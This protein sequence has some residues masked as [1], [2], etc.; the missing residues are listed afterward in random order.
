MVRIRLIIVA[1]SLV[2]IAGSVTTYALYAIHPKSTTVSDP[3]TP[4]STKIDT[5]SDATPPVVPSPTTPPV[6]SPT[7]KSTA[8]ETT[9]PPT[10]TPIPTAVVTPGPSSDV[11]SLTPTSTQPAAASTTSYQSTNWSGYLANGGSFTAVSGSWIAPNPIGTSSSVE[12]ADGTWIGIGGVTSS[13]LIQVGTANTVSP[14]GTVSTIGFYELLPA[15]AQITSSLTVKPGDKMSASIV[16]T[17]PTQWMISMTN[18]TTGQ[19]F[20]TSVS[21]SSSLSSAEWIQE[22]PSYQDGSLVLLDNFGAVQFSNATT[23]MSGTTY[24]A[25]AIGASPITMIGQGGATGHGGRPGTLSG[26]SFVVS[27]Y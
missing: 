4:Q 8:P 7:P 25:S 22:D 26:S 13:D 14:S 2:V 16:Q 11:P 27:Y 23:T 6:K 24:T 9:P 5:V 1:V 12:S 15:A 21:Y 10:A 3:V 18:V 17:A 20:S 19:T